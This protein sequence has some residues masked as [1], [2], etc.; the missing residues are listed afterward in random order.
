MIYFI[1][2]FSGKD[3]ENLLV[4]E[5]CGQP[6]ETIYDYSALQAW[7]EILWVSHSFLLCFSNF[8]LH[9]Y[10]TLNFMR[11]SII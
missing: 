5:D 9:S 7:Y 1:Y 2:F 10:F 4:E 6:S 11:D 8:E 3:Y